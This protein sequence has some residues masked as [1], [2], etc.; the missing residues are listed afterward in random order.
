MK[1]SINNN[2]FNNII[3]LINIKVL[4]KNFIYYIFKLIKIFYILFFKNS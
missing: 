3:N 1:K 2:I 4:K